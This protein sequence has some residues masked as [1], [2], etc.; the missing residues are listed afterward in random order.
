MKEIKEIAAELSKGNVKKASDIRKGLSLATDVD[1][2]VTEIAK[3]AMISHLKTGKVAA[4]KE[5]PHHFS[6]PKDMVDDTI[7]QAVL[8]SFRAGDMKAVKTMKKDL[9]I[10][11]SLG[12]QIVEY[13]QTWGNKDA[14]VAI[15]EVFA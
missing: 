1:L 8:S 11:R 2:E 4:A 6:M 12:S 3:Q 5:I 13:C 14:C 9:P 7:Q 10:S 15:E